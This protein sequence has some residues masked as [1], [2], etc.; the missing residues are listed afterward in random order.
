MS[1][2]SRDL[3]RTF[4]TL[5]NTQLPNPDS[6]DDDDDGNGNDD[7][8][9]ELDTGM[10]YVDSLTGR[11]RSAHVTPVT[12]LPSSTRGATLTGL[13]FLV[14]LCAMLT[15][16]DYS[17]NQEVCGCSPEYRAPMCW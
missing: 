5:P 16:V 10:R 4:A 14:V 6:D 8:D 17:S 12:P 11:S 15:A 7:D 2:A 9:N 3:I 13:S 1:Y